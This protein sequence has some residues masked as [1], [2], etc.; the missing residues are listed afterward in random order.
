MNLPANWKTSFSGIGAGIFSALTVMAALPDT[1]GSVSQIIPDKTK[2]TVV[3]IG[4]IGTIGLRVWN[5]LQQK[6]KNV[7]GGSV[8]QTISGKVADPGTQGLV[9]QTLLATKASGETLTQEQHDI[10]NDLQKKDQ[11]L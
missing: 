1:L 7:T 8:Q 4:L 6:Q 11:T 2:P 10:V 9:D 3:T 5:S